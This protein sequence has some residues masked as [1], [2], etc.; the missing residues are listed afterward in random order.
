MLEVLFQTSLREFIFYKLM[1]NLEKP[2]E[3]GQHLKNI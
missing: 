1:K 2:F 3:Y